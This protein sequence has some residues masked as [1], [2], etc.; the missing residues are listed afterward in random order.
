MTVF[1]SLMGA[2]GKSDM[3]KPTGVFSSTGE[4]VPSREPPGRKENPIRVLLIEDNPGDARLIQEM[5]KDTGNINLRFEHVSSLKEGLKYVGD[6]EKP[7]DAVL[8]DLGLPDSQG[9]ETFTRFHEKAEAFTVI[10]L[11][12]L[13]DVDLAVHAVRS[14]AQDY[15]VKGQIT[16]EILLRSIRHSIEREEADRLLRESQERYQSLVGMMPDSII[17]H[18]QG[19]VKFVN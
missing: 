12:G 1:C 6:P 16:G 18:S 14:G 19:V 4:L 8:L 3:T 9:F 7:L 13:N 17:V 5:L 2:P 10:V 11:S 15:L